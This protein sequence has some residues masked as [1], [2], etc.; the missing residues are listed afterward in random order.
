M[1]LDKSLESLLER[2]EIKPVD[3]KRKSTLNTPWKDGCWSWSSKTLA[4]ET[5]SW[6]TGK[7]PD[8]GKGQ[9]Q[10]KRATEDEI[11]DGITNS[12]DMNL[13]KLWEMVRDREAW[14]A[15]VHG[16]QRV[17]LRLGNWTTTIIVIF[18][19][20]Q[21]QWN[22]CQQVLKGRKRISLHC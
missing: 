3:L 17:R 4:P 7:D 18:K 13:G 16:F 12:L 9:R 21:T 10:E 5:N 8:A 19:K 11:G 15:A 20:S 1:V 2:K 6:L 14:H 22:S